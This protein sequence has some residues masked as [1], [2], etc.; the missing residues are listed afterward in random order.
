MILDNIAKR[1]ISPVLEKAKDGLDEEAAKLLVW[2]G[3]Y[4]LR[5]CL[6]TEVDMASNPETAADALGNSTVVYKKH[7]QK[8]KEVHSSVRQALTEVGSRISSRMVN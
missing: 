8:R 3:W 6:G 1:V 5:R 4:A 7:Y 2:R